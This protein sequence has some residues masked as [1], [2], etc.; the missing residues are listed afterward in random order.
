MVR[1]GT[2]I[3][4]IRQAVTDRG[5]VLIAQHAIQKV[6]EKVC[7]PRQVYQGV[8]LEEALKAA[9]REAPTLSPPVHQPQPIPGGAQAASILV[10]EDD[11][12]GRALIETIPR[13]SQSRGHYRFRRGG[14]PDAS[15]E[16]AVRCRRVGHQ[17]AEPR[18]PQ[19]CGDHGPEGTRHAGR[20]PHRRDQRGCG[21]VVSQVGSGGLVRTL[22]AGGESAK[23]RLATPSS[24]RILASTGEP[25][26]ERPWRWLFD[27]ICGGR[28]PIINYSG[29]TEIAGGILMGNPLLPIKPC[30]FPAP[31]PGIDADV[32]RRRGGQS[33]PRRSRGARDPTTLG[34][35][36][37]RI[38]GGPPLVTWTA[39]GHDGP[40]CGSTEIGLG[41]TRTV[42][43]SSPA[44]AT[45]R[46]MSQES[47]LVPR[48][49]NP[50]WWRILT[51]SKLP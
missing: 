44:G 35:D 50:R 13:G 36:G 30:S 18:W 15:W 21:S 17:H 12:D 11:P 10:V 28:L 9:P 29:G 33:D 46:S 8:L 45:T 1:E 32:G 26:T 39:I 31:C 27:R 40:A 16:Q 7:S 51:C 47:A 6:R 2:P 48:R 3:S 42:I 4:D 38:L 34:R 19:A 37:P 14:S 43:G 24:L 22:M 25:W 49:S 20:V 41:S 23:P 5:D